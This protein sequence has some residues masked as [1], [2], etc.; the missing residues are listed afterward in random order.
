MNYALI[1]PANE[2]IEY[3]THP[4]YYLPNVSIPDNWQGGFLAGYIF[5]LVDESIYPP[6]VSPFQTVYEDKPVFVQGRWKR[7]YKTAWVSK[8][9]MKDMVANI[10][11]NKERAGVKYAGVTFSTDDVSQT[12]YLAILMAVMQDPNFSV[13]WKVVEG[14]L[15]LHAADIMQLTAGIRMYV[16]ACFDKEL[17]FQD[18]IDSAVTDADFAAINPNAGWPSGVLS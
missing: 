7:N 14:F 9:Q 4:H 3:P 1:S 15:T 18:Q 11:Y 8:E 6:V 13:N 5:V 16:Q 10:R 17:D 2:V 12:K